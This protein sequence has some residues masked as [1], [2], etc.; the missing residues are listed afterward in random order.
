[1]SRECTFFTSSKQTSKYCTPMKYLRYIKVTPFCFDHPALHLPPPVSFF[2]PRPSGRRVVFSNLR[3]LHERRSHVLA[4]VA[5]D[6]RGQSSA[7]R[8]KW[9]REKTRK[10]KL[11]GEKSVN[12]LSRSI[13]YSLVSRHSIIRLESWGTWIFVK[14]V[15]KNN[16]IFAM[17]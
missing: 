9:R 11:E 10:S 5:V 14:V 15:D 17:T 3:Q 13:Y 8:G 4:T 6:A 12:W 16:Y 1:M 2:L 7:P